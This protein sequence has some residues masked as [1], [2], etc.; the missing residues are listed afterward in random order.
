MCRRL[1]CSAWQAAGKACW[2]SMHPMMSSYSSLS[3][4]IVG[5][6]RRE[7]VQFVG[8]AGCEMSTAMCRH[9]AA[10]SGHRVNVVLLLCRPGHLSVAMLPTTCWCSCGRP[11]LNRPC[12]FCLDSVLPSPL[13][14]MAV[15]FTA[16][17][18]PECFSALSA[19]Q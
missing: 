14:P 9:D 7:V 16:A 18:L 10:V 3:N 8:S 6:G 12:C 11:V 5:N 17:I 19:S 2:R 13:T 1:T 4:V 15:T